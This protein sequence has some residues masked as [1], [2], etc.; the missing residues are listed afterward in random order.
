[1]RQKIEK[2]IIEVQVF[3][4][5]DPATDGSSVGEGKKFLNEKEKRFDFEN[6]DYNSNKDSPK[7]IDAKRMPPEEEKVAP[8]DR[9]NGINET[10]DSLDIYGEN[11]FNA[12][13]PKKKKKKIIKKKKKKQ[14][15]IPDD[16]A[17][18]EGG[19]LHENEKEADLPKSSMHKDE[20][21]D[22]RKTSS[23]P[24]P[25]KK[26]FKKK[27]IKK[28]PT[29]TA[30]SIN[31]PGKKN[32]EAKKNGEN[33]KNEKDKK[34][35]KDKKNGKDSKRKKSKD[36]KSYS[37]SSK[38]GDDTSQT[39]SEVSPLNFTTVCLNKTNLGL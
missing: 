5:E 26:K 32:G 19:E 39:K 27:K 38:S 36:G 15:N 22:M 28:N 13:K 35:G 37:K 31:S 1:M 2:I 30:P 33:K 29:E 17:E 4:E 10:A 18:M 14:T 8:K 24:I 12:T 6:E 25:K 23:S 21:P 11:Y 16:N 34:K 7:S 3:N 9:T 20:I